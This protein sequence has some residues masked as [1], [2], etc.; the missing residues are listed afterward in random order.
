MLRMTFAA[1]LIVYAAVWLAEG[2][3]WFSDEGVLSIETARALQTEVRWSLF[4]W[5][6]SSPWFVQVCLAVLLTNAVL[7]LLGIFSRFQAAMV[8]FWLVSFQHR[9][10]L[11]LDGEDTV[12]RLFAFFLIFL[13]LDG[14]WSLSARWLGAQTSS[15]GISSGAW[16]IRLFQI[17]MCL[18][19]WS[20]AWSKLS[21]ASWQDGSAL[22]YVYQIG[23]LYGRFPLP[24]WI[25]TSESAIRFGSWSV[26]L[27]EAAIPFLLL[28][29]PTRKFG[30]LTAFS[31]HLAIE[32][33]MNLFLF[34]WVM[35]AGL[36][37][38]VDPSQWAWARK[39][40]GRKNLEVAQG[41]PMHHA[42]KSR[43]LTSE[44]LG[45]R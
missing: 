39:G 25:T 40:S 34:Q 2:P 19:Y 42:D 8:F 5:L 17:E 44:E 12:F 21:S 38:F 9:N 11:I 45:L 36:L 18:I 26:I 32:Y 7:L 3:R 14:C 31:L 35:M 28:F 30:L 27:V 22:Y 16:A 29:R 15:C 33:A 43:I 20:A 1:L 6:P 37:S 10:P 23:D 13:P 4:F 41:V 24:D